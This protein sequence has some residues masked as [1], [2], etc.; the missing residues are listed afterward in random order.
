MDMLQQRKRKIN[1]DGA[2]FSRESLGP[3]S[4][5]DDLLRKGED[6]GRNSKSYKEML[7]E[8]EELNNE[9]E[10]DDEGF[11]EKRSNT[12]EEDKDHSGFQIIEGFNGERLCLEFQISMEEEKRM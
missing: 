2:K 5:D 12:E 8:Q 6:F 1:Q 9:L 7:V 3:I 4:F 11:L 10:M